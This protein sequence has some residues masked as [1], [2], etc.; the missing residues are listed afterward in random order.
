M[1]DT[2][3][4]N[5]EKTHKGL[6]ASFTTGAI[7]L[8]FL[9]VGYQTA[10]FVHKA[11]VMNIVSKQE[12]PDTVYVIDKSMA[13]SLLNT[14]DTYIRENV[15]SGRIIIKK[16]S[17]LS[18]ATTAIREKFSGRQ[19]ES[20]RFDPN[21][22]QI[23]DLMRLGFSSKQAESIDN[24]RKKGGRFRRKEDFAKSYVVADSVYKRLEKYIDIP[25]IDINKADS[26]LFETLPG[27]GP[28]F[29]SRMV[30]YRKRLGGY[31]FI[32]QLMDIYHFD[33]QKFNGLKDLITIGASRPFRLWTLPV[34]SL[35]GHPYIGK[36]AA[37]A[38]KLYRDNNPKELW[39][40]SGLLNAGIIKPE[41][42]EKL[43]RCD[44]ADP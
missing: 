35:S 12:K 44:I 41:T 25:K 33:Q 30:S 7:A 17:T 10:L 43:A 42:A 5:S 36:Y 32:E 37:K 20:F 3:Q 28:Y 18:P 24:Y 39:T 1:A 11:A 8:A 40:I 26:A 6:S 9:V 38:I 29:A 21:T 2:N 15:N 4:K 27:I 19:Y 16:K 14:G 22:I 31:S 34:D 13:E 23:A